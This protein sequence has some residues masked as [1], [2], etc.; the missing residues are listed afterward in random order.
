MAAR[1]TGRYVTS[2]LAFRAEKRSAQASAHPLSQA[3]GGLFCLFTAFVCVVLGESWLRLNEIHKV[4][5]FAPSKA[6]LFVLSSLENYFEFRTNNVSVKTDHSISLRWNKMFWTFPKRFVFYIL[7]LRHVHFF[8][9][10]N[11]TEQLLHCGNVLL[12]FH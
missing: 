10:P 5:R 12:I 1:W 3:Q 9:F 2:M 6:F 8:L 4:R 11:S 7:I